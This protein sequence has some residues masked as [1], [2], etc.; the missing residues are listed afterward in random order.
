M[1]QGR[2]DGPRHSVSYAI[3]DSPTGPF[4]KLDGVLTQGPVVARGSGC[5]SVLN[6][7]GT[8]T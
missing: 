1:V 3:A 2:L 8:D 5:N 7:P 4:A 6:V